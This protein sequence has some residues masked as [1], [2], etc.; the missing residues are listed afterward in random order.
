MP[1][2][3]GLFFRPTGTTRLG[4]LIGS[5]VAHSL[6]PMMHNDSFYQLGIDYVYLCFD[7]GSDRLSTVVGAL[8]EMN[9]YG[10]N[11]TMPHKSAVISCLDELSREAALCGAVNTVVNRSG[12][13]TG[14]NTD[15]TGFMKAVRNRGWDVTGKE[16][17]LIGAGGAGSAIASAAA[18]SGIS[19]LHIACRR[20]HSWERVSHMAAR[21]SSRSG[22]RVSVIDLADQAA[23]GQAVSQSCL[24]VNTT[25]VGMVPD[26]DKSPVAD[27][28]IL[29]DDLWAADVIY[30]PG[31]TLFLKEAK[32]RGLEVMGG[33]EM[34][35]AQGEEAFEL[36]TGKQMPT[37]LIRKRYF[38]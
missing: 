38:S 32:R 36:W 2:P 10:F 28:S 11:V 7:I 33:L 4:G 16:I 22:I 23:F 14:Y 8:R 13:L 29:R 30:H 12:H 3:Q 9:A 19:A 15:G 24:L 26:T 31:T 1:E 6:S 20:S 21:L 35:L 5:P 17:T 18:F 34:L 37:D 27:F 25:S